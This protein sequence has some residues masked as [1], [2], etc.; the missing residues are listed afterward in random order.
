MTQATLNRIL[1]VGAVRANVSC[2]S[3]HS[4]KDKDLLGAFSY[5][6]IREPRLKDP[7]T[8]KRPAF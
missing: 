3:C 7:Q 6:F 4:G 8:K 2:L 1:M 5:E